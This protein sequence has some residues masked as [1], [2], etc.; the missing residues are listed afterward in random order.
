[1]FSVS[2]YN[3][4]YNRDASE[5]GNSITSTLHAMITPFKVMALRNSKQH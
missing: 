5:S 3:L 2:N 4:F 1:M